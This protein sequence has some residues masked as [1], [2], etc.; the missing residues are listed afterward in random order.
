MREFYSGKYC[1][2]Y[3]TKTDICVIFKRKNNILGIRASKYSEEVLNAYIEVDFNFSNYCHRT[4]T[5]KFNSKIFHNF[6]LSR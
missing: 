5:T 2:Y 6:V 4:A 3:H 1:Y